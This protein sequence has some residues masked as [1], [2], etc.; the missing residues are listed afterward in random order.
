MLSG[1][2]A[3]PGVIFI[4]FLWPLF[5]YNTASNENI[6]YNNSNFKQN[7]CQVPTSLIKTLK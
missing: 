2:S 6:I 1:L 4:N 5:R 7:V 3:D